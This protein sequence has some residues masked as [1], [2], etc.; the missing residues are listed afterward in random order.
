MTR[1]EVI[2]LTRKSLSLGQAF[3]AS[4]EELRNTV[5]EETAEMIDQLIDYGDEE[6]V[7]LNEEFMDLFDKLEM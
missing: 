1:E 6:L 4:L 3:Y 5:S 2:E 7:L